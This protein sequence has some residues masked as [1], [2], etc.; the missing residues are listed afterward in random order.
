MLLSSMELCSLLCFLKLC[1]ETVTDASELGAVLSETVADA[2][3]LGVV[4]S[5]AIF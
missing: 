4:L 2:L 3:G 5:E 1:A